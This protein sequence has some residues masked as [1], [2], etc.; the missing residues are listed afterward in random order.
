MISAGSREKKG[1]TRDSKGETKKT[2]NRSHDSVATALRECAQPGVASVALGSE[3]VEA[4]DDGWTVVVAEPNDDAR[5]RDG[6]DEEDEWVVLTD[7]AL[8][9]EIAGNAA[10]AAGPLEQH[11]AA[12]LG[13]QALLVDE[14]AG[15]MCAE[16]TGACFLSLP[17]LL[18]APDVATAAEPSRLSSVVRADK[19][20]LLAR[21]A[22]IDSQQAAQLLC[23]KRDAARHRH[24]C[25]IDFDALFGEAL[26][27]SLGGPGGT[28]AQATRDWHRLRHVRV[29]GRR[30]K[31]LEAF[32]RRV[33]R[34][35]AADAMMMFCTQAPLGWPT[36][37]LRSLFAEQHGAGAAQHET[38]VRSGSG[39]VGVAFRL[40]PLD[41]GKVHVE[42]SNT[43]ALTSLRADGDL[44]GPPRPLRAQLH[45]E[46]S[47]SGELCAAALHFV[48]PPRA[49]LAAI[50]E[51]MWQTVVKA[52]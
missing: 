19:P 30:Y 40:G 44:I 3:D 11:G 15:A 34:H 29:N 22:E 23:L 9:V 36:V 26:V 39:G 35:G 4:D 14:R 25:R 50:L 21:A 33:G 49:P 2:H 38:H 6:G 43:Y 16:T 41:S 27:L 37:V 47:P 28:R 17:H 7:G 51:E 1:Q 31:T 24:R 48:S 10:S 52:F 13:V 12:V 32:R 45:V 46:L 20:G 18:D 8:V 42:M 5:T